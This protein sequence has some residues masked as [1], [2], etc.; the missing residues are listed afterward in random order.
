LEREGRRKS[1]EQ[2]KKARRDAELRKR[3]GIDDL[4]DLDDDDDA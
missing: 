2:A 1:D 3:R 4:M